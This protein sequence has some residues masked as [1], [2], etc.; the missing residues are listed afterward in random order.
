M[1]TL[2]CPR[3]YF[4]VG[5]MPNMYLMCIMW[6]MIKLLTVLYV[7]SDVYEVIQW[8]EVICVGSVYLDQSELMK[9]T[10]YI[11][12]VR[13]RFHLM[14]IAGADEVVDYRSE[15]F[16]DKYANEKFDF[17]FDTTGESLK[18]SKIVKEGGKI[19]T[20]NGTPTLEEI[21]AIG[22]TSFILSMVIPKTKKRIEYKGEC[23]SCVGMCVQ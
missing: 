5:V 15:K 11:M 1:D 16:E 21:K 3:C 10:L 18:M 17:C 7:C 2:L 6:V 4:V 12:L 14:C 20:I 9:L 22:G 23:D 8:Y 19:V 13:Q